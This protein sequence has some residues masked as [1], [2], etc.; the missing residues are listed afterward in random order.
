MSTENLNSN[1]A[2]EKLKELA[3]G[4]DFCFM[5]TNLG[6]NPGHAIPMSTKE[7]CEHGNIWFLSNK[8]SQH[9]QNIAADPHTELY[10]GKPG[11]MEFLV[12][13]GEASISTDRAMIDKLYGKADDTWFEGKDDPN[14]SVIKVT[15][16]DA[17]YWEPKG[18][19]LVS[20]VKIGIGYVTGKKQELGDEGD[21]S[22]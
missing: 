17:H 7:V 5:A 16:K 6:A 10:Y 2:K 19:V 4:I 11:S 21:L 20:L 14:V 15:P 8:N 13:F 12:V 18:N 3:E 1:E 22:I 9:N